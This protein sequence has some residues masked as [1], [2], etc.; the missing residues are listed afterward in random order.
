[1][2]LRR[3]KVDDDQP[4]PPSKAEILEDLE[5]F[6]IEHLKN[7][8]QTR[9]QPDTSLL[10]LNDDTLNTTE[11]TKSNKHETDENKQLT[12]WWDTFEKFIGDVDKLQ[13]YQKQFEVKK[14]NLKQLD[15]SVKVMVDDIQSRI[16]DSLQKARDEMDEDHIDIK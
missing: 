6:S 3:S 7:A 11:S 8:D 4:K 10:S 5:T 15:Q 14:G 16:E 12:E 1:M 9:R 2:F 13:T